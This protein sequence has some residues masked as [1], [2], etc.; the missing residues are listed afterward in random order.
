LLN[1]RAISLD[2]D[3]T[4][5]EIGPV[6]RR[7]ESQLWQWLCANFPRIPERFSAE[8]LLQLREQVVSEHRDLSHDFRFLRKMVLERVA[9]EAGYTPDL[10][11]PAFDVFDAARN[12]VEFFP[13]VLPA[14]EYLHSQFTVIAVT[15]GNANL[16]TIGIRHLFHDVVTAAETGS[17]KPARPIFDEAVRRSGVSPAEMLH[18][19]DN[20]ECD[21]AG[22]M[23][24]GLRTAWM[25]R[26]GD[27]WPE[28]LPEPDAQIANVTELRPLLS[29]Q[30]T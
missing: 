19:G 30:R 18:V 28:A 27:S 20:P 3:D 26:N 10:V 21:I 14:L 23:Q 25:N 16:Q 29:G 5:W 17:A 13:G 9:R 8:D 6:I 4:L 11:D 15:N 12:R 1:I 22:A 24:A 2:L 7:A